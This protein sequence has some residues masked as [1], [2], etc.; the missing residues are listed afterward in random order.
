M[1]E[2][3]YFSSLFIFSL[4]SGSGVAVRNRICLVSTSLPI[5]S[6]SLALPSHPPTPTPPGGEFSF[7]TARSSWARYTVQ[8]S[9]SAWLKLRHSRNLGSTFQPCTGSL[10]HLRTMLPN[11]PITQLSPYLT[12]NPARGVQHYEILQTSYI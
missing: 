8:G 7:F 4:K 10:S 3:C 6:P 9:A 1:E 12:R 5:Y 2:R 11:G